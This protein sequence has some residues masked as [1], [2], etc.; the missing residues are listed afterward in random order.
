[1]TLNHLPRA[2]V[3]WALLSA[4]LIACDDDDSAQNIDASQPDAVVMEMPDQGISPD[5]MADAPDM[6]S[7]APDAGADDP[8]PL[9]LMPEGFHPSAIIGFSPLI[10][11]NRDAVEAA[12]GELLSAGMQVGR[13]QLSWADLEPSPGVF[14]EAA[15]DETLA[16]LRAEGLSIFLTLETI[17]SSSFEIPADLIEDEL[18]L[19]E[20]R[21]FDDPVILQRFEALLTW[22]VPKLVERGVFAV[23]VG[24]E[25]DNTI[26]DR[27]EL[28]AEVAGFTEAAHRI[29]RDLE[30]RMSMSM[31]LTL[32]AV[33]GD[34]APPIVAHNDFLSINYYCQTVDNR[35]KT[36]AEVDADLDAMEALADGRPIIFQELGCSA[37]YADPE[38]RRL[39]GSDAEQQAFLA[40]VL[41][42]FEAAP[43]TYRA[44]YWFTLLDFGPNEAD[45]I[46]DLLCAE[47]FLDL[48]EILRE[49]METYGLL[50]WSDG[51]K[52]PGFVTLMES[53]E[54]A[55]R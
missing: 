39:A 19:A 42:R 17:D 41:A 45:L 29:F 10:A 38:A 49:A 6:G 51:S 36:P 31:T 32:G 2:I 35:V 26:V 15:L 46:A 28:G 33:T 40:Q 48:C 16:P 20:D 9:S 37:A 47:G 44:A 43:E 1:M 53:I 4:L 34:Y 24:N 5:M 52:R 27:P 30:P 14:D 13:A 8:A 54:R 55:S 11:A 7:E 50:R 3:P 22:L 25:P 12:W 21:A 18:T 23:A